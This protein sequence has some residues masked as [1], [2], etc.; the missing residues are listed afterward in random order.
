MEA[1]TDTLHMKLAGAHANSALTGEDRLPGTVNYFVGNDP[2]AMAHRR[3]HLRAGALHRRLSRREPRLLRQPS[4]PGVRFRSLPL[5]RTQTSSD[6]QFDGAR[7]LKLDHDGN[8]VIVAANGSISFHKP[9]VYQ[10]TGDT[11]Q[12]V[13][14]SFRIVPG[15]NGKLHRRTATTTRNRW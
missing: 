15:K 6:L 10:P 2:G 9:V 8:L 3:A 13:E 11:R 12:A 4:A 5:A 14:G 7:K 1:R